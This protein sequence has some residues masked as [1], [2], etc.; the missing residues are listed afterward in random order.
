M[1]NK[2]IPFCLFRDKQ[3]ITEPNLSGIQ[4]H[5]ILCFM[6][7]CDSYEMDKSTS[8]KKN[9]FVFSSLWQMTIIKQFQQIFMLV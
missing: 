5:P 9:K 4:H 6:E 3:P 1:K 2:F 8:K 7:L